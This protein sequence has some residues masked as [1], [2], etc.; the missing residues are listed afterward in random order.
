MVVTWFTELVEPEHA[1]ELKLS[2]EGKLVE[3]GRSVEGIVLPK[4]EIELG[5]VE[6]GRSVEELVLTELVEG[7]IVLPELEEVL[8][9]GIDPW[10]IPLLWP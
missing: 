1:E 10:L 4:V 7:R 5:L 9:L 3:E 2:A 6:E 8:G